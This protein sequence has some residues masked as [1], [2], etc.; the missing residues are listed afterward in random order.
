MS[1]PTMPDT[2]DSRYE[3]LDD[4]PRFGLSAGD[5]LICAPMHWAWAPEKVAVIRRESDGYE[6]GCSQYRVSVRHVSGP[7]S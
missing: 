1:S 7:K 4:D 6:P 3:L 5:I 2:P